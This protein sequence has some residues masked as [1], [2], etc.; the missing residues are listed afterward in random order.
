MTRAEYERRCKLASESPVGDLHDWNR[1]YCNAL[2][3]LGLGLA[4][5]TPELSRDGYMTAPVP[6]LGAGPFWSNST[7]VPIERLV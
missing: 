3:Y 2:S 5:S 6:A 4:K 7:I 1:Q